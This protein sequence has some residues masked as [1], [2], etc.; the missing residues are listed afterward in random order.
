MRNPAL[1]LLLSVFLIF[2]FAKKIR[3][4]SACNL[5]KQI[6]LKAL[7]RE[8]DGG[9]SGYIIENGINLSLNFTNDLLYDVAGGI[10]TGFAYAGLISPQLNIDL[11]KM[12]GWP[13][14]DIHISVNGTL[15][16]NFNKKAGSEQGIDNI[17]AFNTWKIYE[18]WI[19]KKLF[20]NH[21]SFKF[22]LYD[23]N[24][25]F[26][27]RLSSL[28]FLN[29]SQ[30]IG[31]EFSLTGKNGPSIYP[32]T[33]LALR[34]KYTGNS[35]FY[36]Q[37]AVLDGVPGDPGDPDGTHIIIN[38]RDGFLITGEAGFERGADNLSKDL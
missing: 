25:E 38:S 2:E 6:N 17:T 11:E 12:A 36:F 37:S 19:Q 28:V 32:T 1:I 5:N 15:G 35:G 13:E 31:P 30:A 14:A 22:G 24:S 20:D 26:D 29:P 27:V 7:N 10:N 9:I 18:F 21:L 34:I 23:L 16:S 4:Q 3:A 8:S 33:S